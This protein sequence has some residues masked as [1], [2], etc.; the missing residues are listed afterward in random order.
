MEPKGIKKMKALFD[1]L[2]KQ[3]LRFD[4]CLC[5]L[6]YVILTTWVLCLMV[7]LQFI[8]ERFH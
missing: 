3:P 7:Q 1:E 8:A 5:L 6:L 4:P 2:T